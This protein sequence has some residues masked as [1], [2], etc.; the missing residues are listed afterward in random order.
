MHDI[1]IKTV[2]VFNMTIDDINI[3]DIILALPNICRY[4]GRI[5]CH[6]SVGQHAVELARWLRKEGKEELVPHALLH[7]AGEAYIGDIIYPIKI[8]IPAFLELEDKITEMIYKK[9]EVNLDLHSI[10]DFYDKA[11]TVNE[12]KAIG[13]YKE[14][15]I[16]FPSELKN[17]NI[18]VWSIPKTRDEY[19]KELKECFGERI[20]L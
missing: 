2:D 6:Y 8:K 15:K 19:I 5:P 7:D 20:F 10:F 14:D 9:Y 13:I 11:I 12:M 18:E 1:K 16:G 4:G 17:L 3:N